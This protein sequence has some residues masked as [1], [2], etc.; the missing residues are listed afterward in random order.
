MSLVEELKELIR[1]LHQNRRHEMGRMTEDKVQREI[2]SQGAAADSL[3]QGNKQSHFMRFC[4]S[5]FL[6]KAEE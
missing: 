2:N 5:V 6:I 3:C 4:S 1:S